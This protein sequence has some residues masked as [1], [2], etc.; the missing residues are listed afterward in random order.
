[1]GWSEERGG[2][3]VA[4]ND[5]DKIMRRCGKIV[6]FQTSELREGIT[7]MTLYRTIP[8]VGLL[9]TRVHRVLAI[10]LLA[11]ASAVGCGASRPAQRS[12]DSATSAASVAKSVAETPKP[13]NQ[14]AEQAPVQPGEQAVTGEKTAV[15]GGPPLQA[16]PAA[17][18]AAASPAQSDAGQDTEHQIPEG[19]ITGKIVSSFQ[20]EDG[21][22]TLYLNQGSA[23]H[24]RVNMTGS[25]LEGGEGG[26][27][28]AGASFVITKVLSDNQAVATSK[29]SKSLG[30]NNRFMIIKPN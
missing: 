25:I 8:T 23:A 3:H 2:G 10:G 30:K 5:S 26:K 7:C 20:A 9:P 21:T 4:R 29:Y 22:M 15:Q 28:L 18:P 13:F 17:A 27:K 14:G 12:T 6:V 19:A 16:Q 24:L 11:A 1:M